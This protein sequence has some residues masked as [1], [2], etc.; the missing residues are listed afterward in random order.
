MFLI[1]VCGDN[2]AYCPRYI[3]TRNNSATDLEKVKELWVRLG[4]RDP[5][6]HARDLACSGC[7][8]NNKCA[9]SELRACAHA[10]GVD[11][12]GLC[13]AY[14]CKLINTAFE[15][16]EKLRSRA[17]RVCKPE[18][19]DTLQ[20]AFFSKKQNLDRIHSEMNQGRKGKRAGNRR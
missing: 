11:T 13:D 5:T 4:L 15:K 18:E 2:C 10:K 12:C 7:K 20:E 3:A 1:G 9:Y 16:S 6:T 19:L 14:P 8:S 17:A